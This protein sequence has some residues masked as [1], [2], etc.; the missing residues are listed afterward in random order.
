LMCSMQHP[1]LAAC[2]HGREPEGWSRARESAWWLDA[3]DV[4]C[5]PR[6]S[7]LTGVCTESWWILYPPNFF[8]PE[9][10]PFPSRYRERSWQFN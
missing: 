1:T 7:R 2:W 5:C 8:F 10:A 4:I 6:G 9:N 3:R